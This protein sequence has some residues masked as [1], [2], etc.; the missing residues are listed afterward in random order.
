M[1]STPMSRALLITT[2]TLVTLAAGASIASA[3]TYNVNACTSSAGNASWTAEA[4][5]GYATA[6]TA[7]AG[8]GIVARMTG[9]DG[10][11]PYGSGARQVFTAPPGTRIV[12]F[13]A[14]VHVEEFRGWHAGIVD[15]TPRWVWC[16]ATC[17][18]YSQYWE[19]DSWNWGL[20]T[21]QL[22][23]QVTC[24]A[25]N[26]CPRWHLDGLMAMRDVV[27]TLE[28]NGAP[29]IG[30]TGGSITQPG[31]HSGDQNVS[32]YAWDSSGISEI[33]V[34][35]D[36]VRR[37]I[38]AGRCSDTPKPCDNLASGFAIPADY[39][40]SD[41]SHRV[42]LRAI[43]A[44]QGAAE[45]QRDV[46]ID[47]T[48]PAQLLDAEID[49]GINWRSRNEFNVRWRN[50]SQSAAPIVA[51]RYRLCP[52]DTPSG[53]ARGCTEA[54]RRARDV[55]SL[56]N[57]QVPGPGS[58]RIS[59][60]LEDAAGNADRERS[61]TLSPL[62][63]D[64]VAP[65]VAFVDPSDS[66]PMRIRVRA[67][68]SPAG[69]TSGQVEA[70]RRGETAWRSL[71][72]VLDKGG[73]SA[74]L[75]DET[76]PKGL[77]D[78]RARAVDAAG[79]ERSIGTM[80]GGEPAV[81]RLPVRIGT[82]LAVGKRK[83]V[84]ARGAHGRHRYRTVLVVR[85]QAQYGKTIPLT[86]RLTMPGANPLADAVIEVWQRVKLGG[87]TWLRISQVTTSRTGRF[88]FKALKGPSRTLRFRYPG[89]ATIRARSV[90]V[91]LRVRAV[92]SLRVNRPHVVNGEEVRFHGRLKGRQRGETGKLLYLQVFTRGRWSTFATPRANRSSGLWSY[93]Y[94][95]TG[96]RGRVR[97]RFRALVP[98]EATFPYE[99][100]VSHS[101]HVTVR[102]L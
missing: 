58:W 99:T 94:R 6:Y 46:L 96:T 80:P 39:F 57:L 91:D 83:R 8:E 35:I 87:A 47:R 37:G 38:V 40:G 90:T 41:G 77:Y 11:A 29:G 13:H 71:P 15:S 34:Y 30:I 24:G 43:D 27:V 86:G 26:G 89:T 102:G 93:A 101:V 92:T 18:T 81:R 65:S 25:S 28:D 51:V 78:L 48:P 55:T 9:G 49:G 63:F 33:D 32:Y 73:F 70:R 4:P 3:G 97:Y 23:A 82:H 72:T 68:D 67:S 45:T 59:L 98:R 85:P 95:F 64:D 60:W 54:V 22:F 16:G 75:D 31:W 74:L 100:G 76:L 88:R 79:N 84:R 19:T 53:E 5:G 52:A 56:S 1:R 12:H 62:S 42:T 61:V 20:N 50:P 10:T 2:L 21:Q 66:D 14:N 44:A 36:G 69:I 7:C 17:T